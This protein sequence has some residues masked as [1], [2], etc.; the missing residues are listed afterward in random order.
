MDDE[1]LN[2][3]RQA[4]RPEFARQLQERIE[5]PMYVRPS[6]LRQTIKRWSPAL[7]AASVILAAVLIFTLP[8]ARLLAQDFLGLFRVKKFAAITVDPARI[9]ELKSTNLDIE[10]LVGDDV[11]VIKEPGKPVKVASPQEAS[12]RV[13]YNVAVLS[14]VPQD[15]KLETY[16]QGEGAA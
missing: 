15:A 9:K 3:Y 7:L 16:V 12:K 8:P 10:K 13:G 1:F 6:P 4:P 2:Q 11:K 14:N 5:R